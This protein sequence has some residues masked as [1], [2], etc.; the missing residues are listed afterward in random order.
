MCRSA[1]WAVFTLR[2]LF[3]QYTSV[4]IQ[5]SDGGKVPLQGIKRRTRSHTEIRVFNTNVLILG[6]HSTPFLERL[7]KTSYQN[8][9]RLLRNWPAREK[10]LFKGQR[11]ISAS[12][13][14]ITYSRLRQVHSLTFSSKLFLR[15]PEAKSNISTKKKGL[16]IALDA[17]VRLKERNYVIRINADSFE[18]S[19]VWFYSHQAFNYSSNR[20]RYM[21]LMFQAMRNVNG[22]CLAWK[23]SFISSPYKTLKGD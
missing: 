1:L 20:S 10:S 19:S 7:Q 17:T 8:S 13:D 23:A 4:C 22:K 6:H 16:V 5:L 11:L 9:L 12:E 15:H 3:Y 21:F 2:S 14:M 18:S